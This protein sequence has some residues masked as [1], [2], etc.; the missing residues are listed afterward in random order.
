MDA[1]SE[2]EFTSF[3]SLAEYRG[4]RGMTFSPIDSRAHGE[5]FLFP[6]DVWQRY[7]K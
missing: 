5:S 3:E 4:C 7:K 6:M 1:R 2:D